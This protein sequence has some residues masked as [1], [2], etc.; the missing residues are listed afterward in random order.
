MACTME[1]TQATAL[2]VKANF[3]FVQWVK[4]VYKGTEFE[5]DFADIL[6]EKSKEEGHVYVVQ[7]G[8][9][10]DEID[11]F[12]EESYEKLLEMELSLWQI[13]PDLYPQH[14]SYSLFRKWFSVSVSEYVVSDTPH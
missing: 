10:T 14:T 9:D 8:I 4:S 2:I 7:E 12:L 5:D 1:L 6:K 3:P 11:T 13:D